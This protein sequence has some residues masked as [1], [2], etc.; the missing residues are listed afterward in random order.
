MVK[1]VIPSS[2]GFKYEPINFPHIYVATMR[3]CASSWG[4]NKKGSHSSPLMKSKI[5][6]TEACRLK[7]ATKDATENVHMIWQKFSV[8]KYGI[9]IHEAAGYFLFFAVLQKKDGSFKI[10][11]AYVQFHCRIG[12]VSQNAYLTFT[13]MLHAQ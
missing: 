13:H 5:E 3:F 6:F 4:L 11:F 1:M 12:S 10:R 7:L 8:W 2:N 9:F